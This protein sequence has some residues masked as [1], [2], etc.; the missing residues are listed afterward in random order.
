MPLVE[1][2]A[3]IPPDFLPRVPRRPP[4]AEF[5]ASPEHQEKKQDRGNDEQ[6]NFKG[7]EVHESFADN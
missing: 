4:P 6:E 2:G 3:G 5:F 7:T 1:S